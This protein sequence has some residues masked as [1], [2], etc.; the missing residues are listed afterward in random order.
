MATDLDRL[1]QEIRSLAPEDRLRVQ[2][3][4]AQNAEREESGPADDREMADEE[5][6]QL[7]VRAGLLRAAR[8]RRRNQQAFE[9]YRPVEIA[10]EPLSETAIRERR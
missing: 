9:R 6:Q 8:P 7:L 3:A 5:Y 4:L 10:G 1:I 2:E